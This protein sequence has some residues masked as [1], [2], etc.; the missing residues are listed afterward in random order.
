MFSTC[1][2]PQA[3]RP[4]QWDRL[5]PKHITAVDV[6]GETLELARRATATDPSMPKETIA[7]ELGDVFQ[8]LQL[9]SCKQGGCDFVTKGTV[10]ELRWR[11]GHDERAM[12]EHCQIPE[13]RGNVRG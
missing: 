12:C 6:D 10:S 7:Y 4:E 13:D 11:Q 3:T 9:W 8:D 2:Q 1:Q 5:G